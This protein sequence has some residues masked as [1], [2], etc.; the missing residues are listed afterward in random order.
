MYTVMAG[1]TVHR[2]DFFFLK[3]KRNIEKKVGIS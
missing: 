3:K 1:C 2:R